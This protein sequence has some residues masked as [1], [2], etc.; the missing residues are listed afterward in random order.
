MSS[1]DVL[2]PGPTNDVTKS[3]SKRVITPAG[4][5]ALSS[6]D[7]RMTVAKDIVDELLLVCGVIGTTTSAEDELVPVTDCLNWL[8]DLQRA[9]RRDEDMFRPISL[10]IGKWKVV[11]Q[12]LLPLVMTCR[13]DTPMVL[14]VVKILVILTK[15]LA[16]N[17]KRAGR[18]VIDSKKTSRDIVQ[19]QVKLRDN[20]VEQADLLLQYKRIICHHPSHHEGQANGL[21]S[22]FVSLLAEPLSKTGASRTDTDHLTIELVLHLFRNLLAAEPLLSTSPEL[23]R[24]NN[25]I[26]QTLVTLFGKEMVLEIILVLGQELELRENAQYNLLMMELLH[27][28]FKSQDPIAVASC[29]SNEDPVRK[30]NVTSTLLSQRMKDEQSHRRRIAGNR[31]GHFGGTW[32]QEQQGG[33]R[34]YIGASKANFSKRPSAP[35]RK[36]KRAEPF[37]GAT[38]SRLIYSRRA[39]P[40]DGPG[41]HCAHKTLYTFCQ[42]FVKDCYGPVMKSL[43]NEFRR[44]SARLEDEDKVVFFRIVWFL[45]QWWRSSEKRTCLGQLVFTM[46]VF[47]FTL[48]LNATDHFY[49][50]KQ[51]DRLAQAVALY[52]ELLHMLYLM[53]S[54]TDETEGIMAL[55]LMDRLFYTNEPLDRLPRLLSRWTPATTTREYVCDLAEVCHMSLKLLDAHAGLCQKGVDTYD[56]KTVYDRVAKIKTIAAEFDVNAYFCKKIVSNHLVWMYTQLLGQYKANAPLVQHRIIAMFMRLSKTEI[57]LP[58]PHDAETPINPLGTRRATLEPMLFTLPLILVIEEILNDA[59]IHADK[60]NIVLASFATNLM[61]NFWNATQ[62]NPLLYAESLFRHAAPHRFCELATNFYVSDELRMLAER[63]LL[64]EEQ[65]KSMEIEEI[66]NEEEDEAELDFGDS[67]VGAG[68]EQAK[69][70]VQHRE[71]RE[72]GKNDI[73][74]ESLDGDNYASE[75][76]IGKVKEGAHYLSSEPHEKQTGEYPLDGTEAADGDSKNKLS[77]REYNAPS[78]NEM[79]PGKRRRLELGE[80]KL[81]LE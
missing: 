58:E 47:S 18:L 4:K 51:Y 17:T 35:K 21:L 43:K 54:S 8:Q 41:T 16:E 12:K 62:D 45:N 48:V 11:E 67:E 5:L 59:N 27:H 49:Q 46:D 23:H 73:N 52:S 76:T 31:H 70:S 79:Q 20:A 44:D 72:T 34:Q 38:A 74:E 29:K 77:K 14:T 66:G 22:I 53:Q 10:L 78:D 61:Y 69:Q 37:V 36:N 55:G 3:K 28:L 50:H 24:K 1:V 2:K 9:L 81:S 42:R 25:Q 60:N 7:R 32:V 40:V 39:Q 13:Y 65:R 15:P 33:K 30:K 64:L 57:A 71:S 80:D 19:Q 68:R 6:L 56:N 26:H 63:E 75:T